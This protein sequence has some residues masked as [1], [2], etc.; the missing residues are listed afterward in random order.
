MSVLDRTRNFHVR[1]VHCDYRATDEEVYAALKRATD[2]LQHAWDKLRHARRIAI[3]FNQ[4]KM[5]G[6]V[7]LYEGQRQQL[8]TDKV[9]RATLRLLRERT[10]AEIVVVDVSFYQVYSGAAPNS[11]TQIKHILNE[12][13]VEYVN[14]NVGAVRWYDTPGGGL[15]F[16]RYP[17]HAAIAEA[18][19]VVSVQKLKSHAFMGVT[20]CLKNLFGLMPTQPLG[21]PRFYYHHLVRMPYMLADIGRILNPALN[22][23][24]G[25]VCQAG[26]EW[27][28]GD[29][30]RIGNVLIA[31]DHVIATDACGA[32]LMGHDPQAD[33]LTPP[34]HRDRNALKVAAESGFGAVNLQ[35]IDFVSEVQAPV[36]EFHAKITDSRETVISWRRTTAEQGLRYAEMRHELERRYAGQYVL[37]QMGEVKWH[38]PS[39][40]LTRSRRILAGDHPEQAMF[41]K[42]VDPTEAEGEHFEVYERT[43]K[44]IQAVV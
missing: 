42:Y 35:E 3:K 40:V 1:A 34:F 25:T 32:H 21:R 7:V 23:L 39:G 6:A 10:S 33:W 4:D 19:A 15:M 38:D 27:G 2:P 18:D 9:V 43:L 28:P 37:L 30:P 24:D 14:G 13:G 12:F 22:I 20:L 26:E 5:N 16:R 44:E 41:F 31:G 8:V 11:T 36:A 17:L 29:H